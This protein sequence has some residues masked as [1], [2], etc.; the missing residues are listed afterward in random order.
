MAEASSPKA[1]FERELPAAYAESGR[2]DDPGWTGVRAAFLCELEGEGGGTW[3]VAIDEG[4]LSV[5][6]GRTLTPVIHFRQAV[7]DWDLMMRAGLG[8]SLAGPSGGSNPGDFSPRKLTMLEAVRGTV[9]FH[10]SGLGEDGEE[11][12]SVVRFND[13]GDS[14]PS[15]KMTVA[16]EIYQ[17]IQ[18]G[19]LPVPQAFMEGRILIEGDMGLA[20]QLGNALLQ[21]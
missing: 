3:T 20:M 1:F 4:E 19:E 15:F 2:G 17:R 6:E 14:D 8:F 7:T 10:L 11:A 21:G 13:P 9:R 16:A 5:E 18:S 12:S